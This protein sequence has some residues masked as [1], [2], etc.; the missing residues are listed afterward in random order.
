[1]YASRELKR[2]TKMK[3]GESIHISESEI[4]AEIRLNPKLEKVAR[5]IEDPLTYALIR[6]LITYEKYN[7][8][9]ELEGI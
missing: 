3:Q 4:T 2:Y 9:T 5:I 7:F 1:M 8:Q 6:M